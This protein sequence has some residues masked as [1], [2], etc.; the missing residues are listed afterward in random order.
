[1]TYNVIKKYSTSF[2]Q[3][4]NIPDESATDDSVIELVFWMI[5][6]R[7]TLCVDFWHYSKEGFKFN[8]HFSTP[9]I[10]VAVFKDSCDSFN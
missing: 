10:S 9:G 5:M 6:D 1:M 4:W 2:P 3:L 7:T 8:P